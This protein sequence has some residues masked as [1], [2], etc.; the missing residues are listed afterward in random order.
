MPL[1]S[2]Q[3]LLTELDR[4]RA[5]GTHLDHLYL[6]RR[7]GYI[8]MKYQAAVLGLVSIPEI[9]LDLGIAQGLEKAVPFGAQQGDGHLTL[10]FRADLDIIPFC[11]E[12]DVLV[13]EEDA[14]TAFGGCALLFRA[15]GTWE[16][17]LD[18]IIRLVRF[19][20]VDGPIEDVYVEIGT[21]YLGLQLAHGDGYET[22]TD[23]KEQQSFVLHTGVY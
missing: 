13:L 6:P 12:K 14:A 5:H 20:T 10:E 7:A 4:L 16:F 3:R 15:G 1:Q 9:V 23:G 8:I 21:L 19:Q 2:Y 11:I 18:L 17:F 22:H